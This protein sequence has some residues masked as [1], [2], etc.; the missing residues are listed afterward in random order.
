METYPFSW[1]A[2]PPYLAGHDEK[3]KE[4]DNK[5]QHPCSPPIL[6][7]MTDFLS[8]HTLQPCHIHISSGISHPFL[9]LLRSPVYIHT[10]AMQALAKQ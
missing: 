2:S 8:Q 5:S 4:E 10:T 9:L 3:E 7:E 6:L 1:P